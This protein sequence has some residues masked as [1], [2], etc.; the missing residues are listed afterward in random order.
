[1]LAAPYV[2]LMVTERQLAGRKYMVKSI[3]CKY[4]VVGKP[5]EVHTY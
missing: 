1:M 2:D 5:A 3:E 4:S